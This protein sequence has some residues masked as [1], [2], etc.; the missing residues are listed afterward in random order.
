MEQFKLEFIEFLLKANALKVGGDYT[1]KSGRL[2]PHFINI[3][4][5]NDGESTHRLGQAYANA[6]KNSGVDIED[7]IIY[8]IPEKGI[9]LAIATSIGLS[10]YNL[11]RHGS[12]HG[13]Q[14]RR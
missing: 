7:A 2:A 5:F 14:R 13:R 11:I 4:D 12:S 3:G 1:L 9:G 8:G 10:A 6:I